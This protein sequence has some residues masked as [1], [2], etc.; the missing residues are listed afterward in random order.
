MTRNC[1]CRIAKIGSLWLPYIYQSYSSKTLVGEVISAF[2]RTINIK[3]VSNTLLSIA[4]QSYF[5]PI[6]INIMNEGGCSA[7]VDFTKVV[8]PYEQVYIDNGEIIINTI[9]L[10]IDKI[11]G[12]MI[13]T[14]TI[15]LKIARKGI[16][17][18]NAD[19]HELNKVLRK[20]F[21]IANII[22][23][24]NNVI[25]FVEKNGLEDLLKKVISAVYSYLNGEIEKEVA[26]NAI[27]S[28]LGL[29]FGYTPSSDD[30]ISG[31]LGILNLFLSY[32]RRD[33]IKLDR[34]VILAKTAWVSGNLIYLNHLG[35]F[36]SV[37]E[38]AVEALLMFKGYKIID[39]FISLLPVGH[40]SGFD[41]F[42]GALTASIMIYDYCN[43][44][45]ILEE[46]MKMFD[47]DI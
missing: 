21:F 18:C 6:H 25:E 19:L 27:Y 32:S 29:G 42:M 40:T 16:P 22:E 17:L 34:H 31:L 14:P 9:S 10:K 15:Y 36:S 38:K 24:Q 46:F 11:L 23:K 47:L 3:T 41:M 43:N 2:R 13:Y 44:V 8:R 12:N 30:F 20:I 7:L 28:F 26:V 4:T 1:Y 37:F 5:S 33:I 35:L 45:G 39:V